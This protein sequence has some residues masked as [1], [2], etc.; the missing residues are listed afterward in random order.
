MLTVDEII[1]ATGGSI[2]RVVRRGFAGISTDTRSITP[3]E[4]FLALKG[5]RFDGNNYLLDAMRLGA[6]A[7]VNPYALYTEGILS[8]G[9]TALSA[10]VITV[11]DTLKALK[12]I[13]HFK[14][15][16]F[17]GDVF[18]IVGSNGKT[19]TKEIVASVLSQ[20]FEVLKTPGNNN[21]HI[22]LPRTLSFITPNIQCLVLEMG[23]NMPNDIKNLCDI[24]M[25]EIAIITN[26]GYE[27][28]EGLRSLDGVRDAELEI[29]PYVNTV[30]ANADDD[31]LMSGLNGNFNLMTFGINNK[32]ADVRAFDI[33]NTRHGLS[34]KVLYAGK[35]MVIN[36]NLFGLFNI[37][38]CLAG[39]TAGILKG[40]T[41]EEIKRGVQ[42]F[43]PIEKRLNIVE[44]K[45]TVIINDTYNANPSS[46]SVAIKELK[47][48]AGT[49]KRT[50]AVLGDMLE[51]GEVSQEMH[52]EIGRMLKE[53]SISLFVA[54]GEMMG[55]AFKEFG[56]EGK[57][58]S[59]P[60]SA[61]EFLLNIIREGD[62]ILIKGSR[63]MKMENVLSV[64][65]G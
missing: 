1:E 26:I 9:D 36:T 60:S 3:D 50:I 58:F 32:D 7:I 44:H 28:L 16:A 55:Y 45:D 24:A 25:P 10:T 61:G 64:L 2:V 30:I 47:T 48:I 46:M 23:T 6:G 59:D 33:D 37:Y 18:A 34:F 38:N 39:V 13:G 31:F 63:G 17:K 49:D 21:N 65:T 8:K 35:E 20:R 4:I 14:R 27:H 53:N 52:R 62:V 57:T 42:S 54:V 40:L 19:T 56:G 11:D 41:Y 15:R 5:E 51:L 43:R 12:A 22:G 29:L